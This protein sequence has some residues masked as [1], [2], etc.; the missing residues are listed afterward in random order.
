[1]LTFLDRCRSTWANAEAF[2]A[3]FT[4]VHAAQIL[5][6]WNQGTA[7]ASGFQATIVHLSMAGM[8]IM[9]GALACGLITSVTA[10]LAAQLLRAER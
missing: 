5:T 7:T 3:F 2:A 9:G 10:R 4:L 8:L 1:M 6:A